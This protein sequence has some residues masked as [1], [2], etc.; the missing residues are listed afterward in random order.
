[1]GA[2]AVTHAGGEVHW[3]SGEGWAW[4]HPSQSGFFRILSMVRCLDVKGS[5]E[6]GGTVETLK[7]FVYVSSVPR[8]I[9]FV[10]LSRSPCRISTDI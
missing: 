7:S 5:D 4:G 9:G 6:T 8:A 3:S 10:F 1:M 2:V